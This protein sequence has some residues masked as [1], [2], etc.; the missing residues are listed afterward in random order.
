MPGVIDN[1]LTAVIIVV[2]AIM[3]VIFRLSLSIRLENIVPVVITNFL[4]DL[5]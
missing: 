1:Q 4:S 5:K 2:A 3:I